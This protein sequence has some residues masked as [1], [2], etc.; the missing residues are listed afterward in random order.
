VNYSVILYYKF[1]VLPDTEAEM[2]WQRQLCERLELKGRILLATEGINGTVSGSR[3]AI[4]AYIEAM[5]EHE[6]F[7]GI[8][9]KRDES[10]SV[11][12]PR[13]SIKTRSEIVTLGV[14]VDQSQ[15][16]TMLSPAEF[17]EILNDPEVVLFDARNNYESAIGKFRGA[18]TPDIKHFKDLPAKLSEYE[19]LKDK[20]VVTY[21]TGGIRCEKVTALMKEQGF[22]DLYQLDGGIIKYAQAY[23]DGAFKGECFVFDER[24]KVGFGDSPEAV[25]SCRV[26]QTPTNEYRNCTNKVCN[27][28]ILL[29]PDCTL[30]TQVCSAA[31]DS[32]TR[33]GVAA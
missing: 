18:V 25:G 5:N 8:S 9:Y 13:L 33:I 17:N 19:A 14:A 3:G 6:Y 11:P 30:T 16:A 29:C 22:K 2:A 32:V 20:K 26:C 1:V 10:G 12:F 21:C 28:L 24:M 7:S 23:P 31:C 4:D 27:Q 15:T